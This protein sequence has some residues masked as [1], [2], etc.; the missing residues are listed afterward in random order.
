MFAL[1]M[2]YLAREDKLAESH[3]PIALAAVSLYGALRLI[4]K[5]DQ[6]NWEE[7]L[8]RGLYQS[9]NPQKRRKF[10]KINPRLAEIY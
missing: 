6:S 10:I 3:P 4:I 5:W 7:I 8:L 1:T 9:W 2:A